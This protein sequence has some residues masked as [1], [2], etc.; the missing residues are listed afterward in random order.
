MNASAYIRRATL[1]SELFEA[2]LVVEAST[3]AFDPDR[4]GIGSSPYLGDAANSMLFVPQAATAAGARCLFRLCGLAIPPRGKAKIIGVRQLVTIAQTIAVTLGEDAWTSVLERPVETPNWAFSDGNVS[5]HLRVQRGPVSKNSIY[6]AGATPAPSQTLDQ[7][8]TEPSLVMS[9]LHGLVEASGNVPPG[10]P[11]GSLGTFRDIRF[12]WGSNQH[13]DAMGYEVAG[14]AIISLWASVKQ[15]NPALRAFLP[16]A[17]APADRTGLVP[18][19]RFLL[20]FGDR[21]A[22]LVRYRHIGGAIVANVGPIDM[23]WSAIDG[24]CAG[25]APLSLVPSPPETP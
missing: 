2:P 6:L 12:P 10:E 18:E 14:P 21:P 24:A 11:V 23:P 13:S 5:W 7:Y 8:S 19:D 17:S 1:P 15:T 20:A 4:Q 9:T 3:A 22:N 16:A 25:R